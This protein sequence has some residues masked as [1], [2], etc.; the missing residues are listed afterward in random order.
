M[1]DYTKLIVSAVAIGVT[2]EEVEAK[3]KE[4]DPSSSYY[5]ATGTVVDV[6]NDDT[7]ANRVEISII[8]QTK[9]GRGQQEFLE[10]M[11]PFVKD[12][13]GPNDIWA[14]QMDEYSVTP[15]FWQLSTYTDKDLY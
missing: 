6:Q 15:R 8:C 11:Q 3:I 1:G 7:F 5:H 2:K 10:W 9:Y 14:I 13:S 12:G 4:L